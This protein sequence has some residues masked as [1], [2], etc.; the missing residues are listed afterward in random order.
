MDRRLSSISRAKVGAYAADLEV[1]KLR[2]TFRESTKALRLVTRAIAINNVTS[3][4]RMSLRAER[5]SGLTLDLKFSYSSLRI[6]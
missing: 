1:E 3:F 6:R 2:I 4:Q 5:D